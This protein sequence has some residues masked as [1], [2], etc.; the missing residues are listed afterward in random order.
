MGSVTNAALVAVLEN[1]KNKNLIYKLLRKFYR[2]FNK[3]LDWD[4]LLSISRIAAWE[5][6]QTYDASRGSQFSSYL[7]LKLHSK[8]I[9]EIRRQKS[10]TKLISQV[11]TRFLEPEY[12]KP[13][14]DFNEI[15]PIVADYFRR[16]SVITL[17]KRYGISPS[18]VRK[19][20]K[21]IINQERQG[22]L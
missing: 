6:L 9:D 7:H 5:A 12:Q 17:G 14:L 18:A 3:L 16:E 15:D 4:D 1:P 22:V 8:I 13:C 21:Q 2:K 11:A 10:Q 19:H 20:I